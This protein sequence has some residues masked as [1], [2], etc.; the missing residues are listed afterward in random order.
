MAAICKYEWKSLGSG[1][2]GVRGNTLDPN[3]GELGG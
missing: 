1:V 3:L 2:A